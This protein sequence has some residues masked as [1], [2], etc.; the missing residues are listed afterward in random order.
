MIGAALGYNAL[1]VILAVFESQ[2]VA[3]AKLVEWGAEW[4]QFPKYARLDPT[5]KWGNTGELTAPK[6]VTTQAFADYMGGKGFSMYSTG[7]AFS[8]SWEFIFLPVT[9]NEPCSGYNDD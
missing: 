3:E 8:E 6:L 7:A 9:L 4:K 2:A 5:G 1:T